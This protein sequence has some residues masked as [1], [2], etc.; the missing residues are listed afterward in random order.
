[1]DDDQGSRSCAGALADLPFCWVSIIRMGSG[2][3]S[4][5]EL[6]SPF[7]SSWKHFLEGVRGLSGLIGGLSSTRQRELRLTETQSRPKPKHG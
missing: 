1:M 4:D 6:K 2:S 5:V 7:R 3:P